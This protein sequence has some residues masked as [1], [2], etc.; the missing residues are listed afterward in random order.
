MTENEKEVKEVSEEASEEESTTPEK[1]PE[2]VSSETGEDLEGKPLTPRELLHVSYVVLFIAAVFLVN[3]MEPGSIG[4]PWSIGII[5]SLIGA[6]LL[7]YSGY[8]IY[9]EKQEEGKEESE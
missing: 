8:R 9:E 4:A 6:A 7:G 1:K 3:A 2:T 5:L